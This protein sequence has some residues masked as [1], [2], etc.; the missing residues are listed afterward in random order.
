MS[1]EVRKGFFEPEPVGVLEFGGV[2]IGDAGANVDLKCEFSPVSS[3]G[4]GLVSGSRT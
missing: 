4:S 3:E 2:G 1:A